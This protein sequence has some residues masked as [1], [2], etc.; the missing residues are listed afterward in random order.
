MDTPDRII[1]MNGAVAGG[2]GL[3]GGR[4]FAFD[5][6]PSTN[7]WMLEHAAELRHGDVVW[8]RAQTAGRGR[9]ARSWMA[10][11]DRSIT[12]SCALRDPAFGA[13]GPNLGQIAACAVADMLEG[14]RLQAAL[15]WP[16]DVLV[17]DRKIAGMLVETAEA[18]STVWVLGIGVN[19]NISPEEFSA[20]ALDRPA[21]SMQV[22]AG[23]PFAVEGIRRALLRQL[24]TWLD[25]VRV[26]GFRAVRRR[27]ES[28]DWLYGHDVRVETAT[29]IAAGRYAGIDEAGRMRI[30]VNGREEALWSGDVERVRAAHA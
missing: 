24:G 4:G 12:L 7:T 27:W 20:A 26:E 8:A 5:A 9:F 15:K 14:Y 18:P 17:R 30:T 6:L 2:E 28:S 10:M 16:N 25:R 3:W 22:E 19:V 11:P 21:T 13:L 29:G 23:T 1:G